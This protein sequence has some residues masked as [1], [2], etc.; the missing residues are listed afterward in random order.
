MLMGLV[1]QQREYDE[2]ALLKEYDRL[3]MRQG[4]VGKERIKV[5]NYYFTQVCE[6]ILP[7]AQK[8][9][10]KTAEEADL[11]HEEAEQSPLSQYL[12]EWRR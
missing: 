11:F 3:R 4:S 6:L 10:L 5:I 7:E 2:K 8:Y 12:Q 1:R 9:I